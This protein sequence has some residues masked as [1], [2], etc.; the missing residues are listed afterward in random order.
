MSFIREL[1][2]RNVIRMAGLYL[3]GA[4]LLVQVSSTVLPMFDAPAWLP[5]SIVMLLAIGF[6]PVLIFS[7]VFELTPGGLKRDAEVKPEE[8]IAPQTARRMDRAIIAVLALALAYFGFDKF[9]LAPRR[10]V[11][12][13]AQ[14]TEHVTAGASTQKSKVNPRSIAVLP[15]VNMSTDAEN[16]FFSDGLSEEILNSLARIDGMQVVGRTSSFQFKGKNEDLRTIGDKLGAASI[17]EGSVRREGD[18]ARITAQ[19]IRASDGIHLWSQ[20]YDRTVQDSLAVQLDIA[21]QVAGALDVV[22][23]DAQRKRMRE[24]GV[25]NV[26]AFIAYQKGV[27]LYDDAHSRPRSESLIATLRLANVEFDRA[28]ALEPDFAL[29]NFAAS[30][31]YEHVMLSDNATQAERVAAQRAALRQLDLALADTHDA[32]QRLFIDVD[33]QVL[34]DDW[35]GL[36]AR[37]DAA[38]VH[39]GCAAPN[40]LP[41][42][43]AAFGYGARYLPL[44]G[45]IIAC[46][47]LDPSFRQRQ[48]EAANL[49]GRPQ[50]AL[51]S[52]AAAE[53]VMPGSAGLTMQSVRALVALGRIDEARAL[54][55]TL[56]AKGEVYAI[57]QAIV[58]TAAG[59]SP[60]SIRANLHKFD[61]RGTRFDAWSQADATV[62]ALTGDRA[63][64][65]RFAAAY[66]ARPGGGLMLALLVVFC[67]CGAPFD[68]EATPNFKARL[69]ESGLQWPPTQ[70]IRYPARGQGR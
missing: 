26:D 23:D 10:D 64:A 8:S 45:R 22:L 48:A 38:L 9:V 13:V 18:R 54:L 42:F 56:D 17:L 58:A 63:A 28:T 30:D 67:Q 7:W 27:K 41:Q 19:L 46:D 12:L 52:V 66:D 33:R 31:L 1:K 37:I 32:Q 15:F 70:T 34:T 50:L 39:P 16:E 69:A 29:A 57:T 2:R 5:R 62:A 24:A 35:R 53:R 44:S 47:P 11:A 4:W 43:G 68:L 21:E 20:T 3:V 40:W 25:K 59:D 55:A 14:T 51:D 6:L 61:R 65:N 49:S 60:A 36:A